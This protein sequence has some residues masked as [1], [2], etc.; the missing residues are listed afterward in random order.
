MKRSPLKRGTK[1]LKRSPMPRGKSQLKR[2]RLKPVSKKKRAFDAANSPQLEQ[3]KKDNPFC[4]CEPDCQ[5]LGEIIHEIGAGSHRLKCRESLAC[6]LHLFA[7]HHDKCQGEPYADGLAR[8]LASDPWNYDRSE[9]LR[10]IGRADTAIT[11]GE[12]N[13]KV[14]K[15][16]LPSAAECRL[17]YEHWC[18]KVTLLQRQLENAKHEFTRSENELSKAEARERATRR[19]RPTE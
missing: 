18:R 11:Q 7:G 13:A 14:A 6:I 9:F 19:A 12:V 10:R 5:E 4:Q 15:Y 1:G 3:F 16:N 17:T 2:T 8:K